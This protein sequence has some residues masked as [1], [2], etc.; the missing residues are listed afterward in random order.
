LCLDLTFPEDRLPGMRLRFPSDFPVT[1]AQLHVNSSVIPIGLESFNH[2]H[3][4]VAFAET[5]ARLR[6]NAGEPQIARPA[7][8]PA[9]G[10]ANN[11]V[12]GP[13]ANP[14]AVPASQANGIAAPGQAQ[15][16]QPQNN[17]GSNL[18]ANGMG[19]NG[20]NGAGNSVRSASGNVV[21]WNANAPRNAAAESRGAAV[22]GISPPGAQQ[23]AGNDSKAV[24][25]SK[26]SKP[27][28][29]VTVTPVELYKE[30]I[31]LVAGDNIVHPTEA[32]RLQTLR[33]QYSITDSQHF[34]ALAEL[35]LTSDDFETM[36]KNGLKPPEYAKRECVVC[37][38]READH[39]VNDCGHVCLC[40][41][42]SKE[43]LGPQQKC[44]KCRQ[45][46]KSIRKVFL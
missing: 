25:D 16:N 12:D 5:V 31:R 13:A 44:P 32:S 27:P 19:G 38:D 40:L 21:Y 10:D 11:S 42:C 28:S 8:A 9:V 29:A 23:Q 15:G 6:S 1:P 39:I 18:E 22:A 24:N 3:M 36:K 26:F 41:I 30:A 46:I 43:F 17:G 14:S 45:R 4:I 7:N 34:E 33:M 37:L 20:V 35:G 2:D